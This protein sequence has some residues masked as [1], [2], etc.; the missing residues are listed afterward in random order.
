[1]ILSDIGAFLV[2]TQKQSNYKKC[3]FSA[4]YHQNQHLSSQS[5]S[6]I[7]ARQGGTDLAL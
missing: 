5:R 4:F 3:L 1:M 6:T 2:L 7:S